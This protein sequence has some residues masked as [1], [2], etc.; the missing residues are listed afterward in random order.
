[1]TTRI[2]AAELHQRVGDVLAQIRYTGERVI[3]ERR[4]KPVAAIIPM[5]DLERLQASSVQS[6]ASGAYRPRTVEEV[7]ASL[8]RSAALHQLMLAERKGN[9]LP[10][11]AKAIRQM[12]EE[13]AR[14][15]AGRS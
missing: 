15:V 11:S 14:R 9:R 3:I 8:A 10:D 1:M 2:K 4:G 12:R 6:N 7:K 13:R 5:E